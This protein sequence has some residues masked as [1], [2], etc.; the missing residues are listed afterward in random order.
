MASVLVMSCSPSGPR[1]ASDP[2]AHDV[3]THEIPE[4]YEY[5]V[6]KPHGVLAL[7]EARGIPKDSARRAMDRLAT[8]FDACLAD[9]ER[10]GTLKPGAA[11]VVVPLGAGGIAGQPLVRVSEGPDTTATTILCIVAPVKMLA[12]PPASPTEAGAPGMA[13]EATW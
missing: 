8:D 11:R 5:V 1:D 10:K 2:H 9:L 12:F 3:V 7:A 13:I 4:G 6:K